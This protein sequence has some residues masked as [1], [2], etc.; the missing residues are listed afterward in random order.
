METTRS[1]TA[2]SSATTSS[3]TPETTT[4]GTPAPAI[5]KADVA[6]GGS[7]PRQPSEKG[8]GRVRLWL[9]NTGD[10]KLKLVSGA[11][12][13]YTT[14]GSGTDPNESNDPMILIPDD[15]E[16]ITPGPGDDGDSFPSSTYAD[17]CWQL[18]GSVA[19]AAIARYTVLDPGDRVTELYT[20]YAMSN[21]SSCIANGEYGLP[22]DVSFFR[23]SQSEEDHAGLRVDYV[24]AVDGGDLGVNGE[25]TAGDGP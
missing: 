3:T 21:D 6:V 16:Y 20:V 2:T 12:P 4:T 25:V 18:T 5:T 17:G 22:S 9:E 11:T 14:F 7:V 8:P 15:R 10:A 13:P 1:A 19:V 24:V 23:P